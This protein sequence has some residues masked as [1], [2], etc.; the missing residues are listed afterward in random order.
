MYFAL[1]SSILVFFFTLA[2]LSKVNPVTKKEPDNQEHYSLHTNMSYLPL[3]KADQLMQG[4]QGTRSS[5]QYISWSQT[6]FKH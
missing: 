5:F 3:E 2:W 4:F 6:F 1:P